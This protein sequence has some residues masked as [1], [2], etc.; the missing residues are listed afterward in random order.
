MT[1]QIVPC[2]TD[3]Q[4]AELGIT[5]IGDRT[6]KMSKIFQRYLQFY[7]L[8]R[9][10]RLTPCTGDNVSVRGELASIMRP[11]QST[12]R[13]GYHPMETIPK[14][15]KGKRPASRSNATP[16]GKRSAI[17][18][19]VRYMGTDRPR[20]FGR[21]EAD[22]VCT[23]FYEL[24]PFYCGDDILEG[25][26]EMAKE[27]SVPGYDFST[28]KPCDLEFVKDVHLPSSP[29]SNDERD[30]PRVF[31][32]SEFLPRQRLYEIFNNV[33]VNAVDEV[34]LYCDFASIQGP[35]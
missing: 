25:I 7:R 31:E 13:F 26:I 20:E 4:L 35:D 23:F 29:S 9:R 27:S 5:T 8:K 1:P 11:S 28:L 3:Q 10:I 18:K 14:R 6:T 2:L 19:N 24:S 15:G 30:L 12:S 22:I 16:K 32:K 17:F 21:S 34:L 33:S